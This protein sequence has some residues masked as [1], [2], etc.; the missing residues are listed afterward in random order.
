MAL[1]GMFLVNVK[2]EKSCNRAPA[3]DLGVISHLTVSNSPPK[4]AV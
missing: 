1:P 2:A 4:Y 3:E